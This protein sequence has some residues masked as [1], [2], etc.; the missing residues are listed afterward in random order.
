MWLNLQVELGER[1]QII[2]FANPRD[3]GP[4]TTVLRLCALIVL[5]VNVWWGLTADRLR[6]LQNEERLEHSGLIFRPAICQ[7][8]EN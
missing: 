8:Y 5:Y 2:C 3:A 4:S 6:A 7:D 1:Q